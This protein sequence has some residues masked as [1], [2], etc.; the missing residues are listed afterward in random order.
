ADGGGAGAAGV[1]APL[2]D[3]DPDLGPAGDVVRYPDRLHRDG[4]VRSLRLFR[5]GHVRGSGRAA[6]GQAAQSLAGDRVWTD[7]LGR[8]R[9]VRGL[10]QHAAARHLFRHYHADLFADLLRHIFQLDRGDRGR[11]TAL[12][13]T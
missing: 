13:A 6:D 1:L 11:D 9:A 4:I 8:G 12:V 2:L 3:G 7:R 5:S 10:F